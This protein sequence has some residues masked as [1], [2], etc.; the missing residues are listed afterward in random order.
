MT[1]YQKSLDQHKKYQGKISMISK[2]P[3]NNKED[4]ATYY[5]P[6]VAEPCR[7]IYQNPQLS[8]TYTSKANTIAVI[9]DWSAVLWLGNIG[10]LASLP[11]ME[12]KAILFK[13]FADINA[14][15]IC[16]ST[17]DPD[18]IIAT[19]RAIA[20]TFWWI[21]LED[22][23]APNC[24]YVEEKLQDQID[25]PVFHDDQHGTAI[26]LLAWLIN[27]CKLTNR[28]LTDTKVIIQ[29]A[30]AWGI[31]VAKLLNA[32]GVKSIYIF[33]SKWILYRG[34]AAMN[35]YKEEVAK[36]NI[37]NFKWDIDKA[38]K[39]S[40]IFVGLSWQKD[41][42]TPENIKQMTKDPI[43]F[44]TSNPDPEIN[45]DQAKKAWAWI[46]A[47]WRSDYENQ[48]NNVLA[49]PWIFK[50][51]LDNGI[52]NITMKHKL[53]AS[54]AIASMGQYKKEAIIPDAFWV[55]IADIVANAVKNA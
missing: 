8:K 52:T 37:E 55:W 9:S 49:F 47:T 24:F 15:P 35:S 23:G 27:A 1:I 53:A 31:A 45:P 2:V 10:G 16:L 4:L 34:R 13:Q 29:W 42:I 21:N 48:V 30:W 32:Y 11:V 28:K 40:D 19:V 22:I 25:I 38:C 17:Q 46:I 20:P 18:E 54:E 12:W 43:I 39:G 36:Y 50:W 6:G 7:A 14:I 33:D 5:S 51:L 3:L 41:S 26:V 44:A